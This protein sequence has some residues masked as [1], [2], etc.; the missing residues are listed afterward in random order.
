MDF[1]ELKQKYQKV[2]V[3]HYPSRVLENPLISV[4][5]QTYQHAAY[6]RECLDSV[7][8]QKTSF[9]YEVLLGEDASTDGT[10]EICIEYAERY[11]EK[12]RLFLHHRANNISVNGNPTGRF[13]FLYNLY[14]AQGE[15]IAICEGDDYWTDPL[16]LQKQVDFLEAN[17]DCVSCHH[18]QEYGYLQEDGSYMVTP[19]P[20]KNH[21]YF[22]IPKAT[23]KE[24]FDNKLRI[25]LRTHMF[26]SI[27]RD[28]PDWFFEVAFG[29]VP[30]SMILGKHGAFGFIDKPMAVYRR[31]GQGVSTRGKDSYWHYYNHYLEWIRIWEYGLIFYDYKYQEEAIN[32]IK[33]FYWRILKQYEHGF[34]PTFKLLQNFLF[35]CKLKSY[36]RFY[37]F[38]Y[39]LIVVWRQKS[40]EVK[41]YIAL[42]FS[43]L[44]SFFLHSNG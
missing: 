43:K 15:Y 41:N 5:I 22:P 21:G 24:I 11:P 17:S 30:L 14:S 42:I 7:L 39:I 19:A 32:T 6:I 33:N 44:K 36:L 29:D 16:K 10:R 37:L 38:A 1:V 27:I 31:T 3:Q 9:S 2:P 12:I 8:M 20:T 18:W 40:R 13:N 35:K 34:Q 23:V 28:F 26:R 25:K 4:C